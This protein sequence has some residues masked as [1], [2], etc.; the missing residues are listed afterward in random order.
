MARSR[1]YGTTQNKVE[2]C[3]PWPM[4]HQGETGVSKQAG[5]YNDFFGFC[6]TSFLVLDIELKKTCRLTDLQVLLSII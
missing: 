2:D 3:P 5:R 4:H 6:P 1:T